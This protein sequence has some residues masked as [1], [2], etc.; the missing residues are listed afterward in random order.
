MKTDL[1]TKPLPRQKPPREKLT[2]AEF[3]ARVNEQKADLINGEIIMAAPAR[4]KHEDLVNILM[5]LLR[6]FVNK[7]ESGKTYL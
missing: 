3:C 4:Y 5:T 6:L 2:Y 1:L 7:M